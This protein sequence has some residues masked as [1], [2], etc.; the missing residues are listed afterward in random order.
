MAQF[1]IFGRQITIA[2][3]EGDGPDVGPIRQASPES[4]SAAP[5]PNLI[6][7]SLDAFGA[8]RW[9]LDKS[10][11]ALA[12]DLAAPRGSELQHQ[13]ARDEAVHDG[14]E[15]RQVRDGFHARRARAQVAQRL[16]AAKQ[17]FRQHRQLGL[18]DGEPL[19]RQ[20]LVLRRP[21]HPV[22]LAHHPEGDHVPERVLDI[23]VVVGRDRIAIVLLIAAG[24]DRVDRHR[25]ARRRGLGLLDQHTEYTPMVCIERFPAR[26]GYSRRKCRPAGY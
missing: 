18:V 21:A 24:D 12:D 7:R 1:S 6:T 3:A 11:R 5:N 25:I 17:E 4:E 22:D 16:R 19:V 2:R 13:P 26:R 8:S 9:W 14:L 15:R 10:L 23:D 20:V